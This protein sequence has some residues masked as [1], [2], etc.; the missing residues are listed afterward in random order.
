MAHSPEFTYR[1]LFAAAKMAKR[2]GAQIMGL[3]AFTKVV[4][5]AGNRC[6]TCSVADH[7]GQQLQCVRRAVGVT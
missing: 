3:G 6:Q 4:G 5:D 1:R 7:D 2:L